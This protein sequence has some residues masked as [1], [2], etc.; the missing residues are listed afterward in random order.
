MASHKNPLYKIS[1][2]REYVTPREKEALKLFERCETF[3]N[4]YEIK[5]T[6]LLLRD[7]EDVV[8]DAITT[9]GYAMLHSHLHPGKEEE[10]AKAINDKLSKKSL[11][12]LSKLSIADKMTMIQKNHFLVY[13]VHSF[14]SL[15]AALEDYLDCIRVM[16]AVNMAVLV[17]WKP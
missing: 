9:C 4:L 14:Q 10:N 13:S 15:M 16:F 6:M 17:K 8:N 5:D 1:D 12:M 2:L 3:P 11:Q 7:L